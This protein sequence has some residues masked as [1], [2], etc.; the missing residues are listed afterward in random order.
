MDTISSKDRCRLVELP[1]ELRDEIFK[2]AVVE[3]SPITYITSDLYPQASIPQRPAL[4]QTCHQIRHEAS[5]LYF[6]LNRFRFKKTLGRMFIPAD[7]EQMHC[8]ELEDMRS[9]S[10]IMTLDLSKGYTN[11]RVLPNW[12]DREWTTGHALVERTLECVE[13]CIASHMEIGVTSLTKTMLNALLFQI[14]PH[15]Y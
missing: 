12:R 11:Y 6:K 13:H 8:V 2:L 15:E 3:A 4:M 1:R 10:F 5:L 9:P 14:D 7:V